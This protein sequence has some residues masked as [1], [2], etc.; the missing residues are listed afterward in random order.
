[1]KLFRLLLPMCYAIQLQAQNIAKPLAFVNV[2]IIPMD[3]ERVVENQ[4]VIIRKNKIEKI[5]AF[6]AVKIPGDATIIDAAGRYLIPGLADMHAHLQQENM[7]TAKIVLAVT[8]S[9]GVTTI[10]N[11]DMYNLGAWMAFW[12]KMSGKDLLTLRSLS[13]KKEII[14]PRIF[15][16]GPWYETADS[17]GEAAVRTSVYK[18]LV[19]YKKAG[20]DFI[21][22]H[23]ES[24]V[25]ADSVVRAAQMLGIPV[26]GHA[27]R[28]LAYTLDTANYTSIEHL[29][30]YDLPPGTFERTEKGEI[31]DE[32]LNSPD[33]LAN[34]E[35]QVRMTKKSGVYN[36][37]TIT[38]GS[39]EDESTTGEMMN[40][41]SG[42]VYIDS[43]TKAYWNEEYQARQSFENNWLGL[44]YRR[45]YV[46]ALHDAGCKLILG[47]DIP[48]FTVSGEAV[49]YELQAFVK[50]G[51]T[52][53]EALCTATKNAAEYFG[54]SKQEGTIEAGKR[55]DLVLLAANPLTDISNTLKI[56]GVVL[57]GAW[58]NY[59]ELRNQLNWARGKLN[60]N[61]NANGTIYPFRTLPE[62]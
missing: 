15:T 16:S 10:R 33:V 57:D 56:E 37:P 7:Y 25:Y 29:G 42:M 19:D 17:I 44:K 58:Y 54:R 43:S 55:A 53:Y 52:P 61:F 22:L 59:Y 12:H 60:Y 49:H 39:I 24:D 18:R 6:G 45:K 47:T 48:A 30:F 5:G 21:K 31:V 34:M 50:A 20:Y 9:Y 35:R 14:S 13:Q 11:V 32:I 38:V 1:M 51:L 4:T 28:S 8:A 40:A 2:N 23:D 26:M 41:R 3:V 46:K 27:K 62:N 36:C